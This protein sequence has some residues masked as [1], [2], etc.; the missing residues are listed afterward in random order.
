MKQG[1]VITIPCIPNDEG[2]DMCRLVCDIEGYGFGY[3]GEI[4]DGHHMCMCS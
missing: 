1:H 4:N 2:D 3:C